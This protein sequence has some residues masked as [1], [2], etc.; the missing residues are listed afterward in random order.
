MTLTLSDFDYYN[1]YAKISQNFTINVNK[2]T[3]SEIKIKFDFLFNYEVYLKNNND[4]V[5][6]FLKQNIGNNTTSKTV[7]H[8]LVKK[9][10]KTDK[11]YIFK[12][13]NKNIQVN[14]RCKSDNFS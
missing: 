9:I 8:T 10:L 13:S 7:K 2:D 5:K 11:A 12:M 4:N 14:S 3:P 1:K 6:N